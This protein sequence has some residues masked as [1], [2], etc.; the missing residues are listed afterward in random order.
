MDRL[1]CVNVPCLS[2]QLLI[3]EH[4]D[5]KQFPTAVVTED[6]P[7]GII[8]EIN[9][10]AKK[11]G[12]KIGMRYSAALAVEPLLHAGEVSNESIAMVNKE[13]LDVLLRFSPEI[14]PFPLQFGVFWVNAHGLDRLYTSLHQWV[15]DIQQT[16]Q[17]IGLTARVCVG[18]S[19]FGSFIA[20]KR[21]PHPIIFLS[22]DEEKRFSRST[23]LAVLPMEPKA[24]IKLKDLGIKT[25]GSFVRLPKGGIKNRFPNTISEWHNFAS[26][27]YSYPLQ[28][29]VRRED[30]VSSRTLATGAKKIQTILMH[31]KDLLDWLITDV[32]K[33]NELIHSLFLVLESENSSH[34]KEK[35]SP[36]RPTVRYDTLSKLIRLRLE[37]ISPESAVTRIELSAERIACTAVQKQLF[38]EQSQRNIEEGAEAFALIRA[39]LG[40]N[41]IQTAQLKPE[42]VPELQ[43][44][45]RAVPATVAVTATAAVPAPG[46]PSVNPPPGEQNIIRSIYQKPIHSPKEPAHTHNLHGPF[47][48]TSSWW[49]EKVVRSYFYQKKKDGTIHWIFNDKT[50]NAIQVQGN[51]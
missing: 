37:L 45:W 32:M 43:F 28:P 42:H 39:E 44:E 9:K 14:E 40:N 50:S 30:Q 35:I 34:Y 21:S 48:I 27:A 29:A 24:S 41:A 18:F 49:G 31:V 26:G 10:N 15:H 13:I 3:R 20:A 1:A 47:K 6:K 12:I 19:R 25:V 4:P 51:V 38:N 23:P 22:Q 7:L 11:G 36:S 8:T 16:L 5:W 33:H 46:I 17:K 2:L